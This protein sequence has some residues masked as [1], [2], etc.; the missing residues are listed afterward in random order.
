MLA[1]FVAAA[2]T[3]AV[4]TEPARGVV[5]TARAP[6]GASLP[7]RLPASSGRGGT[8]WVDGRHGSDGWRGTRKRPWRTITKALASVPR[9]GSV[10]KVLPGVYRSVGTNYALQFTRRASTS[11]P[12][13]VTAVRR[14]SVVVE[15]GDP[16][17]ETLGAWIVRSTGLRVVGFR[18]RTLTKPGSS[19][20]A[21]SMLIEDSS[22]IEIDRCIFNEVSVSGITVRGGAERSSD[23]VWLIANVFRPS[24]G[25]PTAQA[26]GLPYGA[27]EYFGTKGSHWVYAGQ[28]Q[29]DGDWDHVSGTR[30][31]VV[32][33]NVFAGTAAGRH[34]ELGPQAR[35]SFVVD[36]T[37]Y[38]NRSGEVI[39]Q[40]TAAQ[41]A[42]QA[43]ELFSNTSN[44][45]FTTGYNVVANNLFVNL[46]GHAVAG[47]GPPEPGN[48]VLHN[49]SWQVLGRD[50]TGPAAAPFAPVNDGS[51]IFDLGP[52]N[53]VADPRLTSPTHYGFRPRSGSPAVHGAS[54]PF[55]YPFDANGR[56]RPARPAIGALEPCRSIGC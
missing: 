37:F 4:G 29:T 12:I 50:S 3:G 43:I 42:G 2:S 7:A 48:I 13:T 53:Q 5:V 14:G 28:Y 44:A 15:N 27:H 31:L 32:V 49:L 38:G 33:D 10:V 16:G 21:N 1:A 20:P 24:G 11:D 6:L 26:T 9:R 56:R 30:R 8:F 47:S 36:N 22:R 52:G 34:I 25:N 51:T 46:D 39:G 40:T 45:E 54:V 19:I 41:Y 23:D 17:R 35:N 55:T 18:F